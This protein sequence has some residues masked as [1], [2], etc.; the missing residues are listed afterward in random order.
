MGSRDCRALPAPPSRYAPVG[1]VAV[2]HD[3]ARA[4]TRIPRGSKSNGAG[5]NFVSDRTLEPGDLLVDMGLEHCARPI[6]RVPAL[7]AAPVTAAADAAATTQPQAPRQVLVVLGLAAIAGAGF[8]LF[9]LTDGFHRIDDA[10]QGRWTLLHAARGSV[11]TFSPDDVASIDAAERNNSRSGRSYSVRVA[12]RDGRTFSVST[13]SAAC[14]DELRKFATTAN[15]QR[16][17]VRIVR[18]YGANWVNGSTGF[19]LKDAIGRYEPLDS[20]DRS[21]TTYEFWFE[22]G[23][24]AGK[25]MV[26]SPEGRHVRVL[27]NIKVAE[28]G[29]MEFEPG[30]F[31]EASKLEKGSTLFSLRWSAG[32]ESG[33]FTADGLEVGLEKYRKQ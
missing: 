17:K 25:E 14:L 7:S 19:T 21:R 11:A 18:R 28:N 33:R 15:L 24:L 3:C 1:E 9:G 12:L 4:E 27:R 6:R 13:K 16:G 8:L 23:R 31:V 29:T 32:G 5:G 30:S 22:G 20:R 26:A 2:C 10:G